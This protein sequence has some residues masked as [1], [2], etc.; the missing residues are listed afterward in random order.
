MM[1]HGTYDSEFYRAVRNLLHDEI[2]MQ[3]AAQRAPAD[4]AALSARWC[5]LIDR[6]AAHR[7]RGDGHG[8]GEC[9]EIGAP[10]AGTLEARHG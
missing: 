4:E 3:N 6:E 5:E 7:R 8:H 1:F 2:A 9:D 10:H